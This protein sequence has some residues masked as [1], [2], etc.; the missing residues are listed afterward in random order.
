MKMTRPIL[1]V[2]SIPCQD[3]AEVFRLLAGELGA[4]AARYPDGETGNRIHWIRWQ[5]H[6]FDD[7]PDMHLVEAKNHPGYQAEPQ[8]RPFYAVN[9]G[10]DPGRFA[11][12]KL[13]YA[14][15]A[16]KSY[17]TFAKLKEDGEIAQNVRFQV[18]LPTVVSLLTSF[19]VR[20]DRAKVEP[21][22]EAAMKA[23]VQD[24]ASVIPASELAIQWDVASEIIGH[25]G[26]RELHFDDTLSN[27]VDRIVRHVG[28]VP[29]GV[30]AGIH[31]CYGDPGHKHVIEPKNAGTCVAFANAICLKARRKVDW[32]HIP[33]PRG[34]D[35]SNYFEP[36]SDL[37]IPAGTE[38]FL[39]LVHY[40]D[41]IDGTSRRLNHASKHLTNFGL[42]TECGFGRR[43]PT[44]VHRLLEIHRLAASA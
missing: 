8:L 39:G 21:A 22:L 44:T 35:E 23:E 18:S 42:A 27:S 19:V 11:F 28:F 33:I 38:V 2:G 41:G 10:A 34:W 5:R 17:G 25:D 7:N 40:T 3:S 15:E 6:V 29:E 12:K 16:I 9:Q 1:L 14:S 13:G 32:I 30:E 24:M 36:L 4:L 31:L 26:G 20:E 37:R 43:D